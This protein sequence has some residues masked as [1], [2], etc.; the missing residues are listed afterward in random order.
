MPTPELSGALAGLKVLE[1][2]DLDR[3]KRAVEAGQQMG[4]GYYFPYLLTRHGKESV[5]LL[6]EDEGSM[7]VFVW[8][9]REGRPKLD[10]LVA[11][12]PM[13]VDVLGRC[14]ER[15]NDFNGDRSARILRIDEKDVSTVERLAS[16]RVKQ[17]KSQYL[18]APEDYAELA[19]GRFK[20]VRRNVASVETLAEV[21]VAR[22]SKDLHAEACHALLRAWR[23]QS[24][25]ANTGAGGVGMSRRAIDLAGGLP[26]VDLHGEVVLIEGRVAAFAFGGEI[27]PGLGCSFDRRSDAQIRGLSYYHL[28]SLLLGFG[29][30]DLVNDGSD[31]GRDGLRQL[32]DSFRPVRMH[33][34]FRA[35]QR[36][37]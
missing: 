36:D 14:L 8:R 30:Y 28:R 22:F 25:K 15:M 37:A 35:S 27:R 34:E 3:Y 9:L 26:E 2:S 7:C 18:F 20:T 19:G 23:Q 10:L 17:R 1:A 6:G 21:E 4:W 29:E 13:N 32:K 31:A 12:T 24:R 16:L 33:A 11:P 5:V